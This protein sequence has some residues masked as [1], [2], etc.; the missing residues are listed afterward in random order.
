MK[1]NIPKLR[2]ATYFL[3]T[4]KKN[5]LHDMIKIYITQ[6]KNQKTNQKKIT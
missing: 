5:K 6:Q 1:C 3:I 2:D 4:K